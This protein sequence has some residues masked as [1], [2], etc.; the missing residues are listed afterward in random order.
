MSQ[1]SHTA[2]LHL[3]AHVRHRE[4]SVDAHGDVVTTETVVGPIVCHAYQRWRSEFTD[5]QVIG[6]EEL[7]V[8]LM[9]D[10]EVT[11]GDR[12]D[13]AWPDFRTVEAEVIGP[14]ARRINAR[15]GR[16]HHIEVRT[17]EIR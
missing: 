5:A 14:P 2:L 4:D 13:I 17:R 3:T 9:A 16:V 1:A 11:V 10:V 6:V 7:V 15:N 12:I 8:H